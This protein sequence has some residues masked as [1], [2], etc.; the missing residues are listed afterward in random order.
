MGP[1]PS[2]TDL[3]FDAIQA[4][5]LQGVHQAL[6]HGAEIDAI[7][8]QGWTPLQKAVLVNEPAIVSLLLERGADPR[9][10]N[11]AD[12]EPVALALYGLG[13]EYS[14]VF[15]LV[16]TASGSLQARPFDDRPLLHEACRLGRW[17]NVQ[18][19]LSLG[20]SADTLNPKGETALHEIAAITDAKPHH[21][22]C[23]LALVRAGANLEAQD[24]RGCRP[25]H[26][27]VA[28][29]SVSGVQ[30]LLALGARP[31]GAMS[32]KKKVQEALD[33]PRLES[34]FLTGEPSVLAW[35]LEQTAAADADVARLAATARRRKLPEMESVL[36]SWA[37]RRQAQAALEP[38]VVPVLCPP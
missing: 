16:L 13:R 1:K 28:A 36:R 6:A 22:L 31:H 17:E 19:L 21:L 25:I 2:S 32:F 38:D 29:E 5:D 12:H 4:Q 9:R 8:V 33:Q 15:D 26:W 35:A 24:N 18:S 7:G 30:S 3:L 27:A 23:A 11:S 14:A 37:A 34:A 20:A 10:S